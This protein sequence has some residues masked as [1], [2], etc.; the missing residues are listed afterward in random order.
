ME[1][2]SDAHRRRRSHVALVDRLRDGGGLLLSVVAVEGDDE[3]SPLLGHIA[4]SP[5]ELTQPDGKVH[6]G[7]GLAPLAVVPERQRSGVGGLLIREGL[8]PLRARAERF[9]VVLGHPAY[10]P[11]FG[12]QRA[13][14]FG[15][16]WEHPAP[17]EAFMAIELDPGA[18]PAGI[19]RYRPELTG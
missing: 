19:V 15:V 4:F 18:L 11:R 10:Y 7:V 8:Q 5:V 1:L 16:R 14:A 17:E 2:R 12:F 6:V 9:C 13:S 3:A